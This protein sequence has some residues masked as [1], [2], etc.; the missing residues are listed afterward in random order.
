MITKNQN[1]L[2]IEEIEAK[3]KEITINENEKFSVYIDEPEV[4]K[5]AVIILIHGATYTKSTW[6]SVLYLMKRNEDLKDSTIFAPDLRAHGKSQTDDK[7]L[8]LPKLAE[9][10]EKLFEKFCT[11]GRLTPISPPVIIIGHS[12]G[13]LI[14]TEIA[15]RN[16]MRKIKVLLSMDCIQDAPDEFIRHCEDSSHHMVNSFD[17]TEDA[18]QV[19]KSNNHLLTQEMAEVSVLPR[20]KKTDDRYSFIVSFKST[21]KYWKEWFDNMSNRFLSV[22]AYKVIFFAS[23]GEEATSKMTTEL[24]TAH[25]QGKFQLEMFPQSGHCIQEDDPEEFVEKIHHILKRLKPILFL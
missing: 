2:S 11:D 17:S 7:D 25:M 20:L 1:I 6:S 8:S 9:D 3:T 24:V 22:K 10:I 5:S 19:Y 21:Q 12:L 4:E 18:I 16:K 15:V 14:A 13:G 23:T